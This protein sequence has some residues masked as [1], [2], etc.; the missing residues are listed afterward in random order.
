MKTQNVIAL[1]VGAGLIG[2]GIYFLYKS[3]K[4]EEPSKIILTNPVIQ[5]VWDEDLQAVNLLKNALGCPAIKTETR[6]PL[7]GYSEWILIGGQISNPVYVLMMSDTTPPLPVI[8]QTTSDY[9]I[10]VSS[11]G[12]RIYG[13]AGWEISDTISIANDFISDYQSQK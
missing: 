5:Y 3:K 13:I 11:V 2:L 6:D 12:K 7:Y 8:N 9:S 10:A 4:S 1:T